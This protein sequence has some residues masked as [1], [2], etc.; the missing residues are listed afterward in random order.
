M[1][2]SVHWVGQSAMPMPTAL[3]LMAVMSVPA[4]LVSLDLDSSAPVQN[5]TQYN[6]LFVEKVSSTM[7]QKISSDIFHLHWYHADIDECSEENQC[8][9]NASCNNIFGSYTCTCN[10]GYTGDG[11]NCTSMYEPPMV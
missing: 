3:T 11:I 2:M 9:V 5:K 8:D 6:L 10:G 4:S 1:L 7:V